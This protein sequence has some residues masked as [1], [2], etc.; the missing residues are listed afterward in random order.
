MRKKIQYGY[1]CYINSYEM[2]QLHCLIGCSAVLILGGVLSNP[3]VNIPSQC[4][5]LGSSNIIYFWECLLNI[6]FQ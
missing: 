3:E 2:V 1:L 6:I 5:Q 4:L